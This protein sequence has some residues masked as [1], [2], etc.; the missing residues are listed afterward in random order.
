[1]IL[2]ISIY[3]VQLESDVGFIVCWCGWGGFVFM[4]KGELL[5]LEML[6]VLGE[7][8]SFECYIQLFKGEL[9]GMLMIG[10]FDMMVIDFFLLMVEVIGVF[11]S[12]FLGMYLNLFICS[13]YEL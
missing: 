7:V 6:C 3:M 10:V 8:D 5:F 13:F 9:G 1:M 12:K 4:D 2:V 11:F